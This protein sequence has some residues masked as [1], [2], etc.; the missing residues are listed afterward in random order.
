MRA[1]VKQ[2]DEGKSTKSAI[3]PRT[4]CR[5]GWG[6]VGRHSQRPRGKTLKFFHLCTDSAREAHLSGWPTFLSSRCKFPRLVPRACAVTTRLEVFFLSA[7]IQSVCGT[8][9]PEVATS[10]DRGECCPD[11]QKTAVSAVRMWQVSDQILWSQ[12]VCGCLPR[13][14]V[15]R[16]WAT[17]T[18]L[19]AFW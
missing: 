12:L 8:C 3:G 2:L 15:C 1:Q 11:G 19:V 13:N 9:R 17:G 18:S 16:C 6:T 7:A 5:C 4:C 14:K 10:V